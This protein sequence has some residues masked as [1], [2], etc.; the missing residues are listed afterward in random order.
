MATPRCPGQD[1][2]FW[3]P[4][5]IFEVRCPYCEKEIEFWKDEPFRYCAGCGKRVNNPRIDLGCAKWCKFA[6]ECLGA[7]TDETA[8]NVPVI[9]RLLALLEQRL[10]EYPDRLQHARET[11]ARAET[12]LGAEG[13]EPAIVKPAALLAGIA[14]PENE[15]TPLNDFY[16]RKT[17]L[18]Q[19]GIAAGRA[20]HICALVAAVLAGNPQAFPEF[21]VVWDA[22]QL[23]RLALIPAEQRVAAAAGAIV[24]ALRTESGKQLMI[25]VSI[26]SSNMA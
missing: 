2:R 22:V 8:A 10:S 20:D 4:K 13:G 23:E 12:L 6:Q 16:A 25:D 24:Q 11:H 1:R 5:D 14:L 15:E 21:A 17:L 9:D 18:E 3:K 7:V 26:K 19:A